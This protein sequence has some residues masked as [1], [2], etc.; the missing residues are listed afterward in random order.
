MFSPLV[1]NT[2]PF[3]EKNVLIMVKKSLVY[4]ESPWVRTMRIQTWFRA[5]EQKSGGLGTHDLERQFSGKKIAHGKRSCI[6]NKYRAGT[7]AP[8]GGCGKSNGGVN[9]VKRVETVYPG[10]AKWLSLPL[11]RLIDSA[12]M[13]M[14]EVRIFFEGLSPRL[15]PMFIASQKEAPGLFWRRP[16][17]LKWVSDILCAKRDLDALVAALILVKEA[18][19]IQNQT[20]H[21]AACT[22]AMQ[23]LQM[24]AHRSGRLEEQ[25]KPCEYPL[26]FEALF[27]CVA[28]AMEEAH[29]FSVTGDD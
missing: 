22:I 4:K 14:T 5:V 13:E 20:Q 9:L 24:F 12:P 3:G 16:V 19:A 18:E 10:T 23:L 7:V 17:D 29:Y 15:R 27:R 2:S 1:K 25:G 28:L 11:W 8:R 21:K 26:P 6:W